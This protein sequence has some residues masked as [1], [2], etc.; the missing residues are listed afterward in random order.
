MVGGGSQ[1]DAYSER[2]A[3]KDVKYNCKKR[4]EAVIVWLGAIYQRAHCL[5]L[6]TTS[7]VYRVGG[8]SKIVLNR[9]PR[10][11]SLYTKYRVHS[12]VGWCMRVYPPRRQ[13]SSRLLVV[14]VI[15]RPETVQLGLGI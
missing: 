15:R 3:I 1:A 9:D 11:A 6:K 8:G 7:L 10:S 13:W 2:W 14:S 4:L 5:F 12:D